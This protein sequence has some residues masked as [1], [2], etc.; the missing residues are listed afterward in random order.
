MWQPQ[1]PTEPPK[2]PPGVEG[3]QPPPRKKNPGRRFGQVV[4]LKP[5]CVDAYKACHAKIWPEVAKQIKDCNI[6]DCK[7]NQ[8]E[9]QAS[10]EQRP[11]PDL[12]FDHAS[13]LSPFPVPASTAPIANI[14]R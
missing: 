5:E 13:S 12:P 7:W 2:S 9:C 1:S 6:E 4:K 3:A 10:R 14:P 8:H 11:S